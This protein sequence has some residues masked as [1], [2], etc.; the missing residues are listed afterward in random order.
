MSQRVEW[1]DTTYA[2]TEVHLK[3]AETGGETV[4]SEMA[5]AVFSDGI[6]MIEGTEESLV[7]FLENAIYQVRNAAGASPL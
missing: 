7:S 1:M 2:G 4:T 6:V 3:G 5:L